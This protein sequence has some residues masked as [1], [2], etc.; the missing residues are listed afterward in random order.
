[1]AITIRWT[2]LFECE[3]WLGGPSI[4]RKTRERL[5]SIEIGAGALVMG[6]A[7][8]V[9]VLGSMELIDEGETD[10]PVAPQGYWSRLGPG[11][12]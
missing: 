11:I 12:N 8:P 2:W 4:S 6:S 7:V 1:M 9:R 5:C 3:R 10:Q